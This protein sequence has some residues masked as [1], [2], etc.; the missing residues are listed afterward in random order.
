M[1]S[2]LN[3][4]LE[5]GFSKAVYLQDLT[6][7]CN[8]D[9]R[10]YCNPQQCPKWAKNWVCPPGCGE[11]AECQKKINEFQKGILLQSI[12]NLNPP[13]AE[14]EYKKL[15][16]E[17]NMRLKKLVELLK[18]EFIKVLPLT[19]GGC[20]FCDQCSYPKPCLKPD[21]KMESL[22]AFG[23]DVG[24]LCKKANLPFVFRDDIVYFT[25]LLLLK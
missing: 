13:V 5:L 7:K 10:A 3:K 21:V 16:F 11:L 22:S 25:A 2:Y 19:S 1:E 15:N 8:S 18:P 17:H 23:I 12:T 24:K 6:I 9:L 20:I 14:E 4:I